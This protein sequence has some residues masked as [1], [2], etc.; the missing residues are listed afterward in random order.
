MIAAPLYFGF[1]CGYASWLFGQWN[2][3]PH[4]DLLIRVVDE[5]IVRSPATTPAAKV[6][7]E[8]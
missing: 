6:D 3:Q 4:I 7:D 8:F 2:G 1:L 5:M